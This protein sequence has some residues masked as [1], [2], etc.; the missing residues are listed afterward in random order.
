MTKRSS[1]GPLQPERNRAYYEVLARWFKAQRLAAKKTQ[2]ELALDAGLH[3]Q[4][5]YGLEKSGRASIPTIDAVLKALG[6]SEKDL[7][8]SVGRQRARETR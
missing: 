8:R 7:P 2:G 1:R 4:T 3:A 5:I 6:K